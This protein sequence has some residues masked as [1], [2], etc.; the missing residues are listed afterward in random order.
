MLRRRRLVMSAIVAGTGAAILFGGS[1]SAW[2]ESV[3]PEY[4]QAAADATAQCGQPVVDSTLVLAQVRADSN[5]DSNAVS[6]VTGAQ[7]PAQLFP[8]T[9]AIYGA[10]DDG[11]GVASPFDVADAVHAL[12]RLDCATAG[13]LQARGH[14]VDALSVLAAVAGGVDQ[15][16]HPLSRE[17][18]ERIWS[19]RVSVT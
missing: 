15:V 12:T 5:F 9:F 17:S 8:A 19:Q 18:A 14:T 6:P 16:D 4:V 7:G 3:A 13:E 2:A 11:N 10:D 1:P